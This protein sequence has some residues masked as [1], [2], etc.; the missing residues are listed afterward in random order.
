M[1]GSGPSAAPVRPSLVVDASGFSEGSVSKDT[2]G[3]DVYADGIAAFLIDAKTR[4]PLTMSV[5]GEWRGCGRRSRA[6]PT[7]LVAASGGFSQ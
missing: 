1:S 6:G 5:E 3:F 2:L 4:P 7:S